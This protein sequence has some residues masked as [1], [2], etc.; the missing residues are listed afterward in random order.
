VDLGE[1]NYET[2]ALSNFLSSKLKTDV[3]LRGNEVVG[4]ENLS[5][6]ELER[7]VNKFIYHQNLMDRYWVGLKKGVVQINRFENIEKKENLS[8][9]HTQGSQAGWKT[10]R[11][12]LIAVWMIMLAV[13]L[14]LI[15]AVITFFQGSSGRR[16]ASTDWGGYVVVSNNNKPQPVVVGVSG[17]W[18]VP[19]VSVSQTDT[20]SSAWIGIGG[21][22]DQTLI[23]TGT[24]H[25]S[26]NG[27]AEYSAWFELLPNYSAT[28][29]TMTISPGDK[30]VASIN[31]V[32]KIK[33]EWAVEI[34]DETNGQKFKQNFTYSSSRLSAEWIIEK[35]IINGSLGSLADFGS[36]TFTDSKVTMDT[37][38][39]TINNFP[40][41]QFTIHNRQNTA[42]VTVSSLF[43]NGASFTIKYS[44]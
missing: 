1:L 15:V 28:I 26:I 23:Q 40:F 19:E 11:I 32:D 27:S 36:I 10:S 9:T 21:F 38:V 3:A 29:T 7:L 16:L 22:V 33:N 18:T 41:S 6:K 35:P 31:L 4:A 17:S 13:S 39:G 34:V 42:L 2:E 5:V 37:K 43:S 20:F 8:K 24:T 14:S 25:D 44:K 30:I 12:Y